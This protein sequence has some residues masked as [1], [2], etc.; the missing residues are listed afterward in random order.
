MRLGIVESV[1]ARDKG[2]YL[3]VAVESTRVR[4]VILL[5][6]AGHRARVVKGSRVLLLELDGNDTEIY[7]LPVELA[8]ETADVQLLRKGET[9]VVLQSEKVQ[10]WDGA[11]TPEALAFLSSL[12]AIRNDV[13]ALRLAFVAHTHPG[14]TAGMATTGPADNAGSVANPISLAAGTE[15]TEAA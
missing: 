14:V 4:D 13:E 3:T 2:P 15:I 12:N 7:A 5:Q 6:V 10:I 8:P 9:R 1:T 11:A